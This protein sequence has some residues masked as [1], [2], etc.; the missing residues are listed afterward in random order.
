MCLA[1][2]SS[3]G[4]VQ[5]FR[6][7]K[8]HVHWVISVIDLDTNG[9]TASVVYDPSSIFSPLLEVIPSGP[10][11]NCRCNL[12]VDFTGRE[13]AELLMALRDDPSFNGVQEKSNLVPPRGT[14]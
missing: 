2:D 7:G 1:P 10:C 3:S 9:R 12:R 5:A 4:H 8:P 6:K 11:S 14:V 13:W